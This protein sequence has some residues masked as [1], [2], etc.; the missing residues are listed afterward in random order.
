MA[1]NDT[2]DLIHP[3]YHNKPTRLNTVYLFI[4]KKNYKE[5]NLIFKTLHIPVEIIN[6]PHVYIFWNLLTS[7]LGSS[8]KEMNS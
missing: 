8:E 7:K 4:S 1:H 5:Q 6:Y 3:N 2:N